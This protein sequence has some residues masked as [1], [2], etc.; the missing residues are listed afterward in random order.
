[1]NFIIEY[2]NPVTSYPSLSFKFSSDWGGEQKNAKKNIVTSY[3]EAMG[4]SK[5]KFSDGVG[6]YLLEH[7]HKA[8]EAGTEV[9]EAA[10]VAST[11]R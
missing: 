9:T 4:K 7:L 3:S 8:I 11:K 10:T 2:G 5:G 6:L 1:M